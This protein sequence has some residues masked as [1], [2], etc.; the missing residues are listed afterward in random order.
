[1]G[2]NPITRSIFIYWQDM[3]LVFERGDRGRPVGHA[4]L[5]FRSDD[6]II[7]ATY[8]NVPP[9]K[10]DI[11]KFV[12]GFLAGAMQ[13]MDLQL[14][15]EIM[16]QPIPP[17]AEE[18][19]SHEFLIALAARRED[20]LVYAGGVVRGDVMRLMAE[21]S[22]AAQEYGQLYGALSS[23]EIAP[24]AA[25]PNV[26]TETARFA[27]MTESERLHELTSITGRLRDSLSAGR[28]DPS[29]EQE[30]KRLV[31]FLPA[32]YRPHAVARAALMPGDMGQRLAA[33]YIERSYKLLNE[34]YLDLER[35]DRE[36]D[37]IES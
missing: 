17:V 21:T 8:V 2:S 12:P 1:M 26:E 13:G 33:L 24:S 36:I 4:L 3:N 9:I 11:S 14:G 31:E 10:F 27:D 15:G 20:D 35:I 25:P 19:P 28:P 6:G 34:D 30:L 18:V 23:E 16:A 7:L 37:A 29:L 5:Y 32:K 22:E